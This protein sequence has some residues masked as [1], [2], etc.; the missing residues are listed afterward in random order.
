MRHWKH[1]LT[2]LASAVALAMPAMTA[3]A[4]D[5]AGPDVALRGQMAAITLDRAAL[6]G[7]Y[8]F[9]GETFLTAD[10]ASAGTVDAAALQDAGFVSHYLSVYLNPDTGQQI[11]TYVSVWVDAD[12]AENGFDL[13][14]DEGTTHPDG[15]L[16]DE[17]L[18]LGESPSELTTGT[19]PN[20]DGSGSQVGVADA[21][22]RVDRFLVG[23]SMT[24][25]DGTAPDASIVESLAGTAEARATAVAGGDSPE[26]T[27][28]DL[29]ANV[30]PLFGLGTELQ[31]GFLDA[32]DVEAMYGLTGSVLGDLDA[33]WVEVIGAGEGGPYLSVSAT[34]FG[35]VEDAQAVVDQMEDLTPDLQG[36]EA[37]DGVQVSGADSAVAWSYQSPA[38]G[39]TENDSV[40]VVILHGTTLAVADVQGAGSV[41]SA[42]DAAVAIAS[43]QAVC[44]GEGACDAPELPEG[45]GG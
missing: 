10:Q 26:G 13:L 9:Q 36:I 44:L 1:S 41:E 5:T 27:N 40:R 31:A 37:I 42:Q 4:Q 16:T 28:L 34:T 15:T 32:G 2:L 11:T 22:F 23:V 33:S 19:Y 39:A 6:P 21:T 14:E 20:P 24:T 30:T 8:R 25:S 38:T 3:V 17:D 7:D 18:S 43:A 29:V 35:S 45:F 12:S